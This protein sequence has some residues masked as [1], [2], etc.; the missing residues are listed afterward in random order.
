MRLPSSF[1]PTDGSMCKSEESLCFGS[2]Y[3]CEE[4][5]GAEMKW[6]AVPLLCWCHFCLFFYPTPV[7]HCVFSTKSTIGYEYQITNFNQRMFK[8]SADTHWTLL[9]LSGY[10]D[11]SVRAVS[12][13]SRTVRE[14][15]C[16][17]LFMSD[18]LSLTWHGHVCCSLPFYRMCPMW[19]A[20]TMLHS[21]IRGL[22]AFEFF[23]VLLRRFMPEWLCYQSEAQSVWR[24][25]CTW[26]D[27]GVWW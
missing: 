16:A 5:S 11:I 15:H 2:F 25:L 18:L 23:F 7:R 22:L 17:I 21:H 20:P 10:E 14:S 1:C 26:K 3:T 13:A 6:V 12:A 19:V 27:M 9:V 8:R 4:M 24:T